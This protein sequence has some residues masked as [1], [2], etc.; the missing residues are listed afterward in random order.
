VKD[1]NFDKMIERPVYGVRMWQSATGKDAIVW[2]D[3]NTK[4]C[5][6]FC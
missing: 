1:F 2:R 4:A 3:S 5:L 6:L